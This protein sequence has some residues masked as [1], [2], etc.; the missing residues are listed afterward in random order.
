MGLVQSSIQAESIEAHIGSG[1]MVKKLAQRFVRRYRIEERVGRLAYRL[2]LPANSRI[3]D[4]V[5]VVH[6]EPA[7]AD[8]LFGRQ[9]DS[10]HTP[11]IDPRFPDDTDRYNIE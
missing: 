1:V 8:D 7:P 11:T 6:L 5:S 3:H 9:E 10:E 2:K 4:V